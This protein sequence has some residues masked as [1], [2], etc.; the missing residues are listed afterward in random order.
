MDSS[1]RRTNLRATCGTIVTAGLKPS[2]HAT[3]VERMFTCEHSQLILWVV[4]VET[5]EALEKG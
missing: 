4:I 3:L 5:D 1:P 2:V